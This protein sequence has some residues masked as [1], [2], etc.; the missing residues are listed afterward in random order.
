MGVASLKEIMEGLIKAD[1]DK[2][3]PA[4]IIE[5][6]TC[7]NQRMVTGT[8]ENLYERAIMEKI[9]SPSVIVVGKVCQLADKYNWFMKRPL[10]GKKSL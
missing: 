9:K 10:L 7:P 4:A 1:M 6:G 2:K 3:T 5:N 8:V